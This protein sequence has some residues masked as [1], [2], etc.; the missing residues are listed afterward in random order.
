[1]KTK[2]AD[3]P[4][5]T[6]SL[7]G[8]AIDVVSVFSRENLKL[9]TFLFNG[10]T[11]D[12]IIPSLEEIKKIAVYSKGDQYYIPFSSLRCV[13]EEIKQAPIEAIEISESNP[14]IEAM[15]EVK[16]DIDSVLEKARTILSSS[17]YPSVITLG[18]I[19]EICFH[20]ITY[21]HKDIEY[22]IAEL[23]KRQVELYEKKNKLFKQP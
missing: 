2:K 8:E 20:L 19:K 1:M 22:Q 17:S 3:H 13:S 16:S 10:Q 7:N 21:I 6:Y 23:E 12:Y 5:F 9:K 18:D 4:V 14:K 15:S 11:K